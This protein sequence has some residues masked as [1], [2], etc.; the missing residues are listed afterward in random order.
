MFTTETGTVFQ[1]TLPL[2]GATRAPGHVLTDEEFQPTLP[3]R[4]ATS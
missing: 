3:L 4:G 1:P 2:R